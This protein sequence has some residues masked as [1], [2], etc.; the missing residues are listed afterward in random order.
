[1]LSRVILIDCLFSMEPRL[2]A[3]EY[4]DDF[5]SEVTDKKG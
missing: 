5:Y 3:Y 4:K 2:V 1:M